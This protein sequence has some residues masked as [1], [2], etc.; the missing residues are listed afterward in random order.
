[1]PTEILNPHRFTNQI[2]KN[3]QYLRNMPRQS[4][5]TM[6][7]AEFK[8]QRGVAIQMGSLAISD[9]LRSEHGEYN[10]DA[11]LYRLVAHIEPFLHAQ[12]SA[13]DF[14]QEYDNRNWRGIPRGAK[15]KFSESKKDIIA[16]N[17]ALK[18]VINAGASK[19]G[20]NDL[21]TFMTNMNTAINGVRTQGYFH[22][23]A[24][25]AII[26][27][28]NE[29]GF[30][31]VLIAAGIEYEEGDEDAD[32]HGGDYIID[33]VPIDIKASELTAENARRK[34]EKSGYDS[35]TIIWPQINF[36]DFNGKLVLPPE[37]IDSKVEAVSEAIA[38][39]IAPNYQRIRA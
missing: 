31:Q 9:R 3:E 15:E 17:H 34:A 22:T 2:A 7:S 16:F 28:R 33:N 29:V 5:D 14:R 10:L 27:M 30:E 18:E 36:E 20:F 24:R 1:M 23:I 13:D 37:V 25:E 39:A 35:S 21:L 8:Q 6:A 26:G 4:L 12:R 11:N 19:F 38:Q 32:A